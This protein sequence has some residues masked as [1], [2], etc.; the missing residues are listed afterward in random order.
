MRV[1]PIVSSSNPRFR[2]LEKLL[3]AKGR[4]EQDAF[5]L[6][7]RK[8][9]ADGLQAGC[10][11]LL[12]VCEG[13]AARVHS[14]GPTGEH[15]PRILLSPTLFRRLSQVETNQGLLAV[16]KRPSA[17]DPTALLQNAQTVLILDGV[18]DPGNVGTLVRSAC[19]AGVD[20][21]ITLPG[22]ADPFSPKAVRASAA[23]V[24]TLPIVEWEPERLIAALREAHLPLWVADPHEGTTYTAVSWPPRLALAIGSEGKGLSANL[25]QSAQV[26]LAIP[27]QRGVE[28]LNAAISGSILLFERGHY[29][30][31]VEPSSR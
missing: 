29:L 14:L 6:E 12:V 30:E 2:R 7:G 19:A 31:K 3:T 17:Q 21:L 8:A 9:I 23:S 4:R 13:Q 5:L 10:I 20:L 16:A 11:E 15:L 22:T 27:L 24:L 25:R 28:S 1:E 26:H 18:Q